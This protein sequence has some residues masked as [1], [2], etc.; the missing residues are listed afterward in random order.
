MCFCGKIG[1]KIQNFNLC[2]FLSP[3]DR[4]GIE[5][6]DLSV[7]SRAFYHRATG[8]QQ[9]MKYL[10]GDTW[11]QYDKTYYSRNSRISVIS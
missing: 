6:L 10:Q 11:G 1:M 3:G 9:A 4:G 2:H 8:V 7:L 5:T